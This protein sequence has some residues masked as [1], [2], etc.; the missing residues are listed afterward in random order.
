V[1]PAYTWYAAPRGALTF[2][3]TRT[4]EYLGISNDHPLR[5]GIDIGAEWDHQ[6]AL[7]H[8]DDREDAG[9]YWA[10]RLRAGEGG[11]HSYRVR[12]T[13]E[14]YRWFHTRMEPLRATD[15]TLLLWVGATLD[16]EELKCAGASI[17]R[18]RGEIP[19]LRG[20]RF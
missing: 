19:R 17:A 10:G 6:F 12:G 16:I 1:L 7:L 8:P 4:A 20:K 2:V 11:G 15:G 3:N 14:D 5:F 9:Q 13:Q 18:E